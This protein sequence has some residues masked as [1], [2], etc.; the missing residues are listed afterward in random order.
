MPDKHLHILFRFF[1]YFSLPLLL[2][3]LYYY[4]I[5][6]TLITLHTDTETNTRMIDRLIDSLLITQLVAAITPA[7]TFLLLKDLSFTVSMNLDWLN[8]ILIFLILQQFAPFSS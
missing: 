7:C 2:F 4:L 5:E 8:F 1:Y 3:T 6:I